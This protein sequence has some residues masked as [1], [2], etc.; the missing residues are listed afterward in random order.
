MTSRA[1]IK[2]MKTYSKE[3]LNMSMT[4]Q[5]E[6]SEPP[7]N[8]KVKHKKTDTGLTTKRHFSEHISKCSVSPSNA[9]LELTQRSLEDKPILKEIQIRKRIVPMKLS[10]EVRYGSEMKQRPKFLYRELVMPQYQTAVKEDR[11]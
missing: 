7:R 10:H 4:Y 11:I 2:L 9:D 3:Y 1:N 6:E 8:K 5:T